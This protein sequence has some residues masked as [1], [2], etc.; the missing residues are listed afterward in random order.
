MRLHGS[1]IPK[2]TTDPDPRLCPLCRILGAPLIMRIKFF[3]GFGLKLKAMKCIL[4]KIFKNK[5]GFKTN[6]ITVIFS[7]LDSGGQVT[8]KKELVTVK[9]GNL[10]TWR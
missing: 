7:I 10:A 4:A 1:H 2:T 8:F 3:T 6:I 9:G 5:S